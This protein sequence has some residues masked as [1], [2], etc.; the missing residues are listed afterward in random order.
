MPG[1]GSVVLAIV[2]ACVALSAC[3]GD[4]QPASTAAAPPPPIQH[5]DGKGANVVVLA[6]LSKQVAGSR[7]T[8]MQSALDSLVRAVPDSDRL[9]LAVFADGFNPTVP[10]LS[11]RQN[12]ARLRSAIH[13]FQAGGESAPYDALLQAYGIQ[14]ELA[15]GN[16]V[17]SVLV[18]AHSEDDASRASF[19]RVRKLIASQHRDA[20]HVRVFTIAYD[21]PPSSGLSE[22][23][24]AFAKASGGKS[25]SATQQNLGQVLRE[26]WASL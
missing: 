13:R 12:R 26:A 6:D 16:R 7:L 11:A 17:N 1:R 8:H 5:A 4:D 9:G 18:V 2:C 19:A 22:A 14:R 15:S 3:G 25:F 21:T 24:A 20:L 23:L 10:V